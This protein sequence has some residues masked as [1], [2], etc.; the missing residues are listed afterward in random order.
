MKN[1]LTLTL[2]TLICSFSHGQTVREL[3]NNKDFRELVKREN[4]PEKLSAEELYMVG[5]AFFQTENDEKAI[6]FYDKAILNGLK[7]GAVHFY[8]G[9]SLRYLNS[10]N[11]ALNEI[12]KSLE[13]EPANQEFMNEKGMVFYSQRNYDKALEIFE[14]AQ[15]LPNT[16]PEPYYWAARIYHEKQN[17]NKALTSYYDAEKKLP[18]GNSNYLATLEAIGQ[19][20]FTHTKDFNKSAKAYEK[21]IQLDKE[22][23]ELYYKLMKSYNS[24]KEFK[25]A[26]SI[27]S[28][29]KS[30]YEGKKLPKEDMELKAVSIA[31]FDWNGQI[32]T[33]RKSLVDAIERL[34]ISYKVFLLNK[35]GDQ[36][37]RR[38]VVEKTIQ[39]QKQSLKY[40]LCE[41]DKKTG[42]HI[43]YPYGW[44]VDNIPVDDLEDAIRLVLE[45]KMKQAASSKFYSK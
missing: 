42:I 26:D 35:Q 23:Y 6:A 17:F 7:N 8:K 36:V 24:A 32:A 2:A 15:K 44:S 5:Y 4:N 28:I 33:I 21:A 27:F 31:Q 20:E 29:V 11:E 38:F 22:N 41:Q 19:L 37:E 45:E 12:E 30:A 1:I 14:K 39:I 16:F 34:D 18:K 3:Y 25:K 13:F 43:T 40:I 10:Y 9:L